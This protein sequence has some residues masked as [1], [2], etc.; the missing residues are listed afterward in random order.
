MKFNFKT[1]F[2]ILI[3]LFLY[4]SVLLYSGL[5]YADYHSQLTQMEF[6]YQTKFYYQFSVYDYNKLLLPLIQYLVIFNSTLV[7]FLTDSKLFKKNESLLDLLIYK[8]K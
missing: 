4:V 3:K 8:E 6:D 1:D 7:L 5:N 2:P